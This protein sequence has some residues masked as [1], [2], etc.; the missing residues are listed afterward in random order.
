MTRARVIAR[1]IRNGYGRDAIAAIR[2]HFNI[3]K[4][5]RGFK[6][7][8]GMPRLYAMHLPSGVEKSFMQL[9]REQE[10]R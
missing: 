4:K 8:Y 10:L 2:A 6:W 9:A 5:D 7:V 3:A 1:A